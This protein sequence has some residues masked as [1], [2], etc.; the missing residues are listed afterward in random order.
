MEKILELLNEVVRVCDV[1]VRKVDAERAQLASLRGNL[2][3]QKTAQE[4]ERLHL[5]DENEKLKRKNLIADTLAHAEQIL[6]EASGKSQGMKIDRDALERD[7]RVQAD[8]V[9]NENIDIE[10]RKKKI[11]NDSK[12]LEKDKATYKDKIVQ[13]FT[14][15]LAKKNAE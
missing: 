10:R 1:R 8:R 3:Q 6:K 14:K 7:K 5:K 13:D 11:A 12:A 9:K 15:N 2:N 4:E